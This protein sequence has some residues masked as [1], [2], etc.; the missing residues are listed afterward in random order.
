MLSANTI[1]GYAGTYATNCDVPSPDLV[2]APT[3]ATTN[4]AMVY[5]GTFR[6]TVTQANGA[7]RVQTV[8]DSLGVYAPADFE[9]AKTIE[10]AAREQIIRQEFVR[11]GLTLNNL[12]LISVRAT[13][14][15]H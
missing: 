4:T 7:Q 6:A 10:L 11:F 14:I 5:I 3:A 1:S 15:P 13:G 9:R 12:E 8:M 2:A